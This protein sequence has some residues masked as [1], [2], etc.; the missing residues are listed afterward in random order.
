MNRDEWIKSVEADVRE[1]LRIPDAPRRIE[2]SISCVG[3]ESAERAIAHFRTVGLEP[4]MSAPGGRQTRWVIKGEV[5]AVM[6]PELVADNA[7][8]LRDFAQ[9]LNQGNF[10]GYGWEGDPITEE[11]LALERQAEN[12]ALGGQALYSI[13]PKGYY[14]DGPNCQLETG[15]WTISVMPPDDPKSSRA[16]LPELS[17]SGNDPIEIMATLA[18]ALLDG[19]LTKRDKRARRLD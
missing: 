6:S 16:P 9:T 11:E 19:R 7:V 13:L 10:D 14:L 12:I 3:R 5:V 15:I 17:F 2:F 1:F 4:S 18:Q 8:R